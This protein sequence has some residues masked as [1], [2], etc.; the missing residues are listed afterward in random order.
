MGR[1]CI[2]LNW[3]SLAEAL[4]EARRDSVTLEATGG[5]LV[6]KI[7]EIAPERDPSAKSLQWNRTCFPLFKEAV[8]DRSDQ[9]WGS[10][11]K[12][13]EGRKMQVTGASSSNK[14]ADAG[15]ASLSRI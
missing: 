15:A 5:Q 1:R 2:R 14:A 8:T 3:K 4:T 11:A 6:G 10:R 7:Y 12:R 13:M 9:M